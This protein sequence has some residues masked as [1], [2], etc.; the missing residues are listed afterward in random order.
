M[1][2]FGAIGLIIGVTVV[3]GCASVS[4]HQP[5][6]VAS[7]N[8]VS[9]PNVVEAQSVTPHATPALG[10][11]TDTGEAA[12]EVQQASSTEEPDVAPK[13][14]GE[15]SS[16]PDQPSP[17]GP[18][19]PPD[20]EALRTETVETHDGQVLLEDVVVSVYQSYPLLAAAMLEG[21]IADGNQVA[22][23]GAFDTKL[24]VS[25]ENGPTGFYQTYRHK[26]FVEQ[27]L[28]HGGDAFAGYR[29]GRGDFQPWYLERQ[30]NDGGEFSAG[31]RVPL[32]RN[33]R[34]DARR[35]DLWRATYDQQRVRPEIRAQ[36]IGFVWEGSYAYWSWIAAGRRYDIGERALKLS[37]DRNSAL[38][39]RVEE[40][41][42][43]PP[44]L[45]DN[46]R[47]IAERESKLIDRG[48]KLQQAAVKLSL[49]LRAPDGAPVVPVA[50]QLGTFPE[51]A[52][53]PE[54]QLRSDIEV[55]LN[56]RPELASLEALRR[57]INVDLAEACNDV[58]PAIDARLA[59]SQDVGEPTSS[60]RDK[61]EFEL[62]AGVFV[63]V[64]LQ[65]RKGRG[66][67]HAAR[68]KLSQIA[69]KRQFTQDKIVSEVQTVYAALTAAFDRVGKARE[70]K[71]LAEYMAEVE[72][73]KFELGQTDLLS[74]YIREQSAIDAA[75]GEVD[76]LLEYFVAEA[77]YVAVLAL[78]WPVLGGNP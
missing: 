21:P 5:A 27:P 30:T 28:Y 78:D 26:A 10:E 19:L 3:I 57:R 76:A 74:V 77:D 42:L 64:P 7:K 52:R 63:E 62:E 53:I 35:A 72:R 9:R 70:S 36:L 48:R 15:P 12:G 17:Q 46:L 45:Q 41:D 47:S 33:R 61:S 2:C 59:G 39:R 55:A 56:Q 71:R 37:Q 43:D 67:A 75:D 65:R 54:A 11:M 40:G 4:R 22:A 66:K 31:L 25:S 73:R 34:I 13:P 24:A 8:E 20:G 60:K 49:F 29:I 32:M 6:R 14:A 16:Q 51:P 58:L 18:A 50:D 44:A 1:R 68:A 69:A 23:W 38:E